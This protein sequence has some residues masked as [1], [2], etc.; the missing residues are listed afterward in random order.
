MSGQ[1][2]L[3]NSDNTI[4]GNNQKTLGDKLRNANE[5]AKGIKGIPCKNVYKS[6]K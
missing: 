1:N 5:V 3:I 6:K 4:K 2:R